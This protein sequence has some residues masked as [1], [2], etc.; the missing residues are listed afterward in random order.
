[1]IPIATE[2]RRRKCVDMIHLLQ[3]F[4]LYAGHAGRGFASWSAACD[5][6]AEQS[7]KTGDKLRCAKRSP[8]S[9]S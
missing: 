6:S 5:G 8:T 3:R 9:F 2:M 7:F 1:M 4:Q